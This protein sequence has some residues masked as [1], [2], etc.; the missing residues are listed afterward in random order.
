[1]RRALLPACRCSMENYPL[2]IRRE[3][4]RCIACNQ[5]RVLHT[6]I[7]KKDVETRAIAYASKSGRARI[8][9]FPRCLLEI[10][11]PVKFSQIWLW[12][13]VTM[14][15]FPLEIPTPVEFSQT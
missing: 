10:P 5:H 9:D 1:M 15:N 14:E 6:D 13:T 11:T 8:I 12:A 2:A 7:S 4:P 3:A